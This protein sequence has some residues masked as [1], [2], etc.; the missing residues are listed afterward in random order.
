[1][2]NSKKIVESDTN[3]HDKKF[4]FNRLIPQNRGQWMG[5]A[6]TLIIGVLVASSAVLW[7]QL[8]DAQN[9]LH[10]INSELNEIS[11]NLI[12]QISIAESKASNAI[13]LASDAQSEAE[14]AQWSVDGA[15]D[16][17]NEYMKTVGDSGGGRYTYYLC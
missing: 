17:V 11:P 6:M 16:C 7:V 10:K 15:I 1:M 14:D 4:R 12:A 13:S 5:A 2:N 3:N 8:N 9:S